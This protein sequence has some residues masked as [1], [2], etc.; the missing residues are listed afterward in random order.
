MTQTSKKQLNP[1]DKI[2]TVTYGRNPDTMPD[3]YITVPEAGF[4]MIVTAPDTLKFLMSPQGPEVLSRTAQTMVLSRL[5]ESPEEAAKRGLCA[6][7]YNGKAGPLDPAIIAEFPEV[8]CFTVS[9][10]QDTVIMD[11]YDDAVTEVP[12]APSG[13][14]YAESGR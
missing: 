4:G 1:G 7:Y 9:T 13:E 14:G 10:L 11:V 8:A 3:F 12:P 2:H 5:D 6:E